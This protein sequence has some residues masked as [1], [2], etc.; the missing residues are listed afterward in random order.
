MK[1][2]RLKKMLVLV[3]ALVLCTGLFGL[4]GCGGSEPPAEP[5]AE[6]ETTPT[7][8]TPSESAPAESTPAEATPA[9]STPAP[10]G[11]GD[12]VGVWTMDRMT[13][14]GEPAMVDDLKLMENMGMS[15][16]LTL[17][18]DGTAELNQAGPVTTGTWESTG[19]N[20]VVLKMD[21]EEPSDIVVDG[22]NLTITAGP[23][24]MFY[25]RAS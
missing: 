20:T 13:E 14:N 18:D 19:A 23:M 21:G 8:T 1:E 12:P 17:K 22:D 5:E 16:T 6:A 4:A 24:Q 25:V 7:E 15:V 10:T 11:E 2:L 3:V 9:E